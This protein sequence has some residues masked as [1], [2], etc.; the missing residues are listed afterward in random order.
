MKIVKADTIRLLKQNTVETVVLL[1]WKGKDTKYTYI[2]Y[3]PDH[4]V[5]KVTAEV[6]HTGRIDMLKNLLTKKKKP[7]VLICFLILA[8]LSSSAAFAADGPAA[9]DQGGE[10]LWDA[11]VSLS[12]RKIK[13]QARGTEIRAMSPDGSA[14]LLDMREDGPCLL[15]LDTGEILP[16][17]PAEGWVEEE[18]RTAVAL[19]VRI[20]QTTKETQDPQE[21]AQQALERA[22]KLSAEGLMSAYFTAQGRPQYFVP[23]N[24]DSAGGSFLS[25]ADR[26][27]YFW[28]LDCSSGLLYGPLASQPYVAGGRTVEFKGPSEIWVRDLE[29]GERT[30]IAV[31]GSEEGFLAKIL[32][33]GSPLHLSLPDLFPGGI[34]VRAARFLDDGSLCVCAADTALDLT[35]GQECALILVRSDRTQTVVPIGRFFFGKEPD[36]ITTAGTGYFLVWCRTTITS[37]C[38]VLVNAEEGTAKACSV[39]QGKLLLEDLEDCTDEN[40]MITHS[41]TGHPFYPLMPMSDGR[42]LLIL[43]FG[44]DYELML[45]N[46]A[47]GGLQKLRN[48]FGKTYISSMFTSFTGNG[49]DRFFGRTLISGQDLQ[50]YSELTVLR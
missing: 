21:A 14:V 8:L 40:G 20:P 47:E 28:A 16:V 29:S 38:T 11:R 44:G 3:E 37:S 30:D 2:D 5:T 17:L 45:M 49:Y 26:N 27:G 1:G 48:F 46:A 34:R 43:D 15:N 41:E 13:G 42:T 4:H 7:A 19:T 50:T 12:E 18:L 10:T 36:M 24:F 31:F 9:G 22:E 32:H 35:R 39:S 33:S 23:S 6:H 25:F